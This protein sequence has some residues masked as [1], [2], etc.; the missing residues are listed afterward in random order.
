[1][2]RFRRS[3]GYTLIE[4]MMVLAILGIASALAYPTYTGYFDKMDAADV[5]RD[6]FNIGIKI[7]TYFAMNGSY[8]PDLASIGM[9]KD[10]PWGNPYQYL[11]MD[12]AD[13]NGD[14]RKDHNLVPINTDYD[15]YSKGPDGM[16]SGPL[17][18]SGSQDDIIRANNGGYIG[19][20]ADY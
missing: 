14:K 4:A 1:M 20:A 7:E 10:D 13:G 5:E 3:I 12:L 15:L 9:A 17:T 16:S 19:V 2:Q 18:A 8:P 6:F 11:N